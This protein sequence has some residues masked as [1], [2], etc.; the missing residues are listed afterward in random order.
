M[1]KET[2]VLALNVPDAPACSI[3]CACYSIRCIIMVVDHFMV[4]DRGL[5]VVDRGHGVVALLKGRT[6]LVLGLAE[7]ARFVNA[8]HIRV[9]IVT[10]GWHV[11]PVTHIWHQD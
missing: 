2:N 11:P 7:V 3:R 4:V 10:H 8:P 5:L 9:A 6:V 1:L